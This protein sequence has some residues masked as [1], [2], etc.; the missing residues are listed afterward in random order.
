MAD[1]PDQLPARDPRDLRA[2][3]ADRERV[4][5]ILRTAAA[6]GRL[7]LDELDERLAVV[8]AAR[9]YAD[10]EPVTVDL[11]AHP[12]PLPPDS[13]SAVRPPTRVPP[14]SS[15]RISTQLLRP[16]GQANS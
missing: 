6:E 15:A 1:I 8:Y 9:T 11:P 10:L 13:P 3:D 4:A 7:G 14:R 2:S 5:E 12:R 16:H